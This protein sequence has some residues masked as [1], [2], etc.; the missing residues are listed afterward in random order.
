MDCGCPTRRTFL[1][2]TGM[3]FTGLVLGA[4]L[5]RDSI[6]QE[7]KKHAVPDGRPHFAPGPR[8]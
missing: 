5:H 4:L 3:G 7:E 8:V 6:S 1:A 2:D